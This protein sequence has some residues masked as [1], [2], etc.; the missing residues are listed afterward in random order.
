MKIPEEQKGNIVL[1]RS[2][3]FNS[4]LNRDLLKLHPT[5]TKK[6]DELNIPNRSIIL[7]ANCSQLCSRVLYDSLRMLK[8]MIKQRISQ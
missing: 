2:Y 8:L 7:V 4:K 1:K 3:Y 5:K 6:I